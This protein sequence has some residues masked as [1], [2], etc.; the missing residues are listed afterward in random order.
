MCTV[1]K[2]HCCFFQ[3]VCGPFACLKPTDWFHGQR[4]LELLVP[5]QRLEDSSF[6]C[7]G[8]SGGRQWLGHECSVYPKPRPHTSPPTTTDSKSVQFKS[9][10]LSYLEGYEISPLHLTHHPWGSG[11][12]RRYCTWESL[13]DLM[14]QFPPWLLSAKQGGN[15]S[16]LSSLWYDPAGARTLN[17]T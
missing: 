1:L 2:F 8:G 5:F 4:H 12:Q 6:G 14:P 13:A 9:Q 3:L 15:G 7:V 17:L 11:G 10:W 16:H